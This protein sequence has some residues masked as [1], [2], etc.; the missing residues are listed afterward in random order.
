MT[1]LIE[2]ET[3]WCGMLQRSATELSQLDLHLDFILIVA[4]KL[5]ETLQASSRITTRKLFNLSLF[6]LL[7]H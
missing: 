2:M 6:S 1:N 4:S 7:I 5:L 3:T